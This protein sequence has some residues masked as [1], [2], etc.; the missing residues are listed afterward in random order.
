MSFVC[1]GSATRVFSSILCGKH[2]V[3]IMHLVDSEGKVVSNTAN[4][5]VSVVS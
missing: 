4:D 3:P 5:E 2:T 1:F